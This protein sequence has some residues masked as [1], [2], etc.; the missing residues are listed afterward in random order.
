MWLLINPI[1]GVNIRTILGFSKPLHISRRKSPHLERFRM[2][3]FMNTVFTS[4]SLVDGR[5]LVARHKGVNTNHTSI[6]IPPYTLSTYYRLIM[7]GGLHLV[8]V[9]YLL[10]DDLIIVFLVVIPFTVA[11]IILVVAPI[12]PI[13]PIFISTAWVFRSRL[14]HFLI[15][16]T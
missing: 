14:V 2:R 13:H 4:I 7:G 12:F 9:S 3:I 6:N 16:L 5:G 15:C 11:G 8:V 1:Y 10:V